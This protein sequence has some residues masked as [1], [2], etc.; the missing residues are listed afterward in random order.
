[1]V[2]VPLPPNVDLAT[3]Q[4]FY[5]LSKKTGGGTQFVF[6]YRPGGVAE[7]NVYTSLPALVAAAALVQGVKI[8]QMDNSLGAVS[9]PAGIFDFGS[10]TLFIGDPDLGVPIPVTFDDLAELR[11]VVGFYDLGLVSMSSK[12]VCANVDPS[13]LI[14]TLG[15]KT[16]L[17]SNGTAPFF[18]QDVAG[19]LTVQAKD[20]ASVNNGAVASVR[21]TVPGANLSIVARDG[22]FWDTSTVAG[23]AGTCSG[24]IGSASAFV[25]PTQTGVVGPFV[26]A[27][28]EQGKYVQYQDTAPLLGANQVQAAIDALKAL[29]PGSGGRQYFSAAGLFSFVP[30]AGVTKV[31]VYGRPGASGGGGGGAGGNGFGGPTGGGGGAGRAGTGGAS[32]QLIGPY[33]CAVTPTVAVPVVVGAGGL[34]G[35]GGTAPGG[36]GGAGAGGGVSSFDGL[37]FGSINQSGGGVAGTNAANGTAGAGGLAQAG[38]NPPVGTGYGALSIAGNSNHGSGAGGAPG[39]AGVTPVGSPSLIRMLLFGVN[40]AGGGAN[41]IGGAAG[42]GT[43]GGGGGGNGS[44]AGAYGD[45]GHPATGVVTPTGANGGNGG[46]GNAAGAGGNAATPATCPQGVNGA[47]GC[48]GAGGGGGGGGSTTGGLGANGGTA[49]AGS[50]GLI[51]VEW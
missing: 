18:S 38:A 21:T 49:A 47:G 44:G 29:I 27:I 17:V 34:G 46:A 8:V 35:V 16:T 30:P 11:N 25:D 40:I 28:W 10:P 6:V 33:D 42:G 19:P 43:H 50:I 41:G 7:K 12:P 26:I 37:T 1:M 2:D 31:S 13:S 39:V 20:Y 4:G 5:W 48:G 45:A 9:V 22:G 51:I 14:W 24:I 36:V 32:A 15:G 3:E 23:L